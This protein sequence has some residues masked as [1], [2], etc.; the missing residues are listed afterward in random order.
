VLGE[1]VLLEFAAKDRFQR[2]D[3]LA[4]RVRNLL[5]DVETPDVVDFGVH[6]CHPV[7]RV[8]RAKPLCGNAG[9][10]PSNSPKATR[11]LDSPVLRK[12]PEQF[13]RAGTWWMQPT[14]WG[15]SSSSSLRRLVGGSSESHSLV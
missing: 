5:E 3:I 6:C 2:D 12:K 9:C 1:L 4:V 13:D 14:Y 8:R 11:A 15:A 7:V 10:G